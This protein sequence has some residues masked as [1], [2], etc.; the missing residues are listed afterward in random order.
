[1]LLHVDHVIALANGGKND[2]DNLVT[3][4]EP[5]NLGKGARPLS[6]VPESLAYK[7]K[8]IAESEAQ[9]L[10]YQAI[11]EAKRQRLDDEM[12]RVADEID[13]GA[14]EG[15]PDF[16]VDSFIAGYSLKTDKRVERR[17][18]MACPKCGCKTAYQFDDEDDPQDDRL[19]RCAACGEVFDLDDHAEEDDEDL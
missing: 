6:S 9:L 17:Q 2:K 10:G 12:W 4:C 15:S 14:S 5:C 7:A 19:Q 11:L 8:R 13:T 3:S 16:H 1:V 18:V